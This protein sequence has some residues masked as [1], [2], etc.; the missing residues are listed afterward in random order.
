MKLVKTAIG[1]RMNVT[2]Y[3]T[4]KNCYAQSKKG[5]VPVYSDYDMTVEI[6]FN[7]KAKADPNGDGGFTGVGGYIH[8][9]NAGRPIAREIIARLW[10]LDLKSGFWIPVPVF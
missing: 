1:S 3:D 4:N 8:P 7:A 9:N 2:L 5:N 6:H 10:I